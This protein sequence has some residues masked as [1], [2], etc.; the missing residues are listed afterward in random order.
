MT[1]SKAIALCLEDKDPV[2]FEFLVEQYKR[3][4]YY[5]ALSFTNNRED[6]ADACQDAFRKAFAAMPKLQALDKFYPWFYRILK[7][8][9]INLYARKRTAQNYKQAT[10]DGKHQVPISV[11]PSEELMAKENKESVNLVIQSLKPEFREILTLKYFSEKSYDEMAELLSIP[12]GTVMSRLYH[13]RSAFREA[14]QTA[15]KTYRN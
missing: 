10:I 9:C 14:F 13:A 8:H 7:N 12:R 6:A 11:T 5:H 1:E 2:G 4:A 15:Q 3:E